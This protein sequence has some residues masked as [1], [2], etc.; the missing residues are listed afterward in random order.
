MTAGDRMR[1]LCVVGSVG[2]IGGIVRIGVRVCASDSVVGG[3]NESD[4]GVFV[5]SVYMV[6]RGGCECVNGRILL[7]SCI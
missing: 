1:I 6:E 4:C 7:S 5:E 3:I 2:A